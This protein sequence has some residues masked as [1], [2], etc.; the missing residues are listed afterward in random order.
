MA[1]L[2]LHLK[3]GTEVEVAGRGNGM[4]AMD[5][6]DGTWN[7][8]LD[9]DTE[10]DVPSTELTLLPDQ[11]S[12]LRNPQQQLG[13][14][15]PPSNGIRL[16]TNPALEPCHD[17][18]TRFVCFSDTHGLHDQIPQAHM[19][20]ADVLLHAGDFTNTGEHEQVE[21][22]RCWLEAYPAAHK[23]IIAGNHDV[24]FHEE[25]YMHG[26][27]ERFHGAN[28]YD[29]HKSR[30][31]FTSEA[32]TYLEDSMVEVLG[33]R[34]YG[35]P[36]QPSFCDWA[37]NLERGA[38]CREKWK[39]IPKSDLD[40][41]ITHGPSKGFGDRS[42]SGLRVGCLDL[43]EA[44]EKRDISVHLSGHVHEGYGC[45]QDTATVYINASTCTGKYRPTNPPVV[46]DAPPPA[47]LRRMTAKAATDRRVARNKQRDDRCSPDVHMSSQI[48]V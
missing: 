5:N 48:W 40:I 15:T 21:S 22:L 14:S 18:W 43:Q 38:R 36:W 47:E 29:C 12:H 44:I 1:T 9:D 34:I 37:F 26:G 11:L 25:Y 10:C 35:S 46:F 42:G 31:L 33:Y 7:I 45:R 20:E 27:A 4:L 24:T 3:V 39:M 32:I 23:V 30:E 8:V 13:L 6:E 17:G 19:P 28:A 41:L 2:D 16:I